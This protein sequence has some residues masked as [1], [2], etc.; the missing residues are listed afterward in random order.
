LFWINPSDYRERAKA[1][2]DRKRLHLLT[3]L[4]LPQ[5]SES[6]IELEVE[7]KALKL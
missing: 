3:G 6:D 7:A 1:S 4:E 2:E 5:K